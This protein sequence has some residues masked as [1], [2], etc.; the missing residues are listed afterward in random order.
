MFQDTRIILARVLIFVVIL[1]VLWL[2]NRLF[3]RLIA[4]PIVSMLSKRGLDDLRQ[5]IATLVNPPLRTI[6]VAI[7]LQAFAIIFEVSPSLRL[8]F[9]NLFRTLIVIAIIQFVHHFISSIVISR[10]RLFSFT[11]LVIEEPLIPFIRTGISILAIAITLAIIIQVWGYDVSGLIAGLGIG[12][13]ALSLAAQ[14]TLSNLFGF[15]AL[16]GDRP[17]VAGEFIKTKDVEGTIEQVGLRST[18][19]RQADQ[20]IV[21]VPNSMLAASAILNWSRLSKRFVNMTLNLS[22]DS[23]AENLQR[24]LDKTRVMLREREFV[25]TDSA[26]VFFTEFGETSIRVLVR[27][28]LL[29]TDWKEFTAEKERIFLE[30][31]RIIESENLK[32]AIPRTALYIKS[33]EATHLGMADAGFENLDNL[34]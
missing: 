3:T 20:A 1:A 21:A 34:Q 22:Y 2:F 24:F 28:Y 33:S 6:M 26:V 27:C 31:M 29:I 17:F 16:I 7:A 18:R 8:F 5:D 23:E 4:Q 25:E 13:L 10:R 19:I 30:I 14:D 11:G 12:G 32:I 9:D 15:T